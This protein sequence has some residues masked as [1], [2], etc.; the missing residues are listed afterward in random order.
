M[1]G[2]TRFNELFGGQQ[3]TD[4]VRNQ[5]LP[6]VGPVIDTLGGWRRLVILRLALRCHEIADEAFTSENWIV[7]IYKVKKEDSL[8]RDHKGANA[9][10]AGKRKKKI[11]AASAGRQRNS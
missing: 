1:L 3:A 9:F 10:T 7:R 2:L 11:K 4:R 8:S 5:Q 6:K